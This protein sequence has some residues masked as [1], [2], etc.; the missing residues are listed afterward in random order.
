[1]DILD[2][3]LIG[4]ALAMDA[5]ALTI[6]N[7]T[8]YKCDLNGKKEWSMPVAFAIFQG[9]MPLIGFLIGSIFAEFIGKIAGFLTA[10]IFF[11]LSGKIIVD[12]LKGDHD[13]VCPV[14]KSQVNKFTFTILLVQG[15]ATSIDALAVGITFISLPF[16]VFIA[17]AVISLVTALLVSLA[18]IFG[19]TLGKLF[20]SYA[21]WIGAGILLV[22]A[23]KSLVTAII[24]I[25]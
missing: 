7:C 19:K 13:A 17:V 22:L 12:N 10:G 14:D 6:S 1:M 25:L 5:C 18:L 2:I 9:I 20:G 24:E 16:S 21:E 11:F 4:V 15:F 23:I 3:I 8:V